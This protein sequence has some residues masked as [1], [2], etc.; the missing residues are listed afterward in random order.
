MQ[1]NRNRTVKHNFEFSK[2]FLQSLP[3]VEKLN[4]NANDNE[5][6]KHNER[7][8]P[9][10]T[11][12]DCDS[13]TNE[14]DLDIVSFGKSS[15]SSISWSDDFDGEATIKVQCELERMERVL[16]GKEAIPPH[17]NKQEYKQW[18]DTFPQISIMENSNNSTPT[19]NDQVNDRSNKSPEVCIK[20]YTVEPVGTT[21]TD[22]HHVSSGLKT[23]KPILTN[24]NNLKEF[25]KVSPILLEESG[26]RSNYLSTRQQSSHSTIQSTKWIRSDKQ[27]DYSSLPY[28]SSAKA[29]VNNSSIRKK[30]K[31]SSPCKSNCVSLPPIKTIS[32]P[33]ANQ[34]K[35][36]ITPRVQAKSTSSAT[37]PVEV[38]L[39]RNKFLHKIGNCD[40][41]LISFRKLYK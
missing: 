15:S 8:T 41:D 5:V 29:K 27:C 26:C 30:Y 19:Q 16:Q 22:V 23:S 24:S 20:P 37:V 31:L 33:S 34:C 28:V 10:P 36:P 11:S 6:T 2:E 14:S 40:T 12:F 1:K 4:L 35:P 39:K 21:F 18:I 7:R 3:G 25:L 32:F 17:Y 9:S 38:K 13:L